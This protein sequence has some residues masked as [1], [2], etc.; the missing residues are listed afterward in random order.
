MKDTEFKAIDALIDTIAEELEKLFEA[1]QFKPL[2]DALQQASERLKDKSVTLN[3]TL[4]I[5]DEDRSASLTLLNMGLSSH[6][7]KEPHRCYGDSTSQRYLVDGETGVGQAGLNG[8]P[9]PR[10]LT[11]PEG[12]QR[13]DGGV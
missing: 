12:R 7:G 13:A 1:G 4:D 5:V 11:L 2:R 8:L 9:F 10:D 3:C 6:D